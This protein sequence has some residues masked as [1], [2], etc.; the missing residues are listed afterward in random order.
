MI[1]QFKSQFFPPPTMRKS[2]LL[3]DKYTGKVSALQSDGS[4]AWMDGS[5]PSRVTGNFNRGTCR[6][7][8]RHL[9]R[10]PPAFQNI[11]LCLPSL[12]STTHARPEVTQL[13]EMGRPGIWGFPK[14]TFNGTPLDS[15]LMVLC[16][17]QTQRAPSPSL[18]ALKFSHVSL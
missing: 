4:L 13:E 10:I 14:V 12:T 8:R 7:Q 18:S 2:G 15:K 6:Q 1:C 11:R 16:K 17:P 5:L 3:V 9:Q